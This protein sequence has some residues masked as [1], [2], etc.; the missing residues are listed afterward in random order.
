MKPQIGI[1]SG[2]TLKVGVSHLLTKRGLLKFDSR[3][4]QN[5]EFVKQHELISSN[6]VFILLTTK[7]CNI[8]IQR[9][10]F[11]VENELAKCICLKGLS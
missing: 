8:N 5:S 1:P 7:R 11:K 10:W 4:I 9:T 2:W 6:Q 3:E